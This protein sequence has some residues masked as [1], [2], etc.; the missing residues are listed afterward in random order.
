VQYSGRRATR[1]GTQV[2]IAAQGPQAANAV[3]GIDQTNLFL[4][5]NRA[6]P[7]TGRRTS[8]YP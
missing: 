4:P 5:L 7:I 3:G 6:L 8:D 2:R 1:A